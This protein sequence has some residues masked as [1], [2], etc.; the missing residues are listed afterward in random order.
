MTCSN[1]CAMRWISCANWVRPTTA[2]TAPIGICPPSARTGRTGDSAIGCR[3]IELLRDAWLAVREIDRARAARIAQAWFDLPYPTFKRLALFAAS[4]DGCIAPEQ[5]VDWLAGRDAWWLWSVDTRREM[6]RLLVLQG[7]ASDTGARRTTG[8]GHPGWPAARDVPRRHR[9]GSLARLGGSLGLAASGQAECI[10]RGALGQLGEARLAELS[11]C[12][13][14]WQLAA[15]ERDEFSHWMSGTGDPDYEESRDVD[16]APRKRRELVQWLKQPPAS[17]GARSTRTLGA[18]SAARGSFT[19]CTR[20]VIWHGRAMAGRALAR[21]AAG[22]ERRRAWCCGPG[23]SPRR[24]CRPCRT[25]CLQEIAHGVTWWLEAVSKSI[26]RHEDILLHMCRRVLALP[27]Q[28]GRW[29]RGDRAARHRGHQSPHR[30]RHAG[31]AQSVV[32]ARAQ[33]Q[34][35]ASGGHWSPLFTQLCDVRVERFRHGRVLLASRLIAFFRVD[36]PWTEQYLL[37]LFDWTIDPVEAKAAWEGFLWSPRLY[38][39]LLIA[40]KPQFLDTAPPLRRVG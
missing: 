33:R 16:I 24:W 4:Q 23:D 15:N 40:F 38:R 13:P 21:G 9:A 19:A 34:R 18:T 1:C 28:D 39:P 2:A 36:R 30:P 32:Q 8:V 26:D 3:L 17:N 14:Q 22:L 7:A 5:W 29:I 31:P 20:C 10:R 27:H 6:L 25:Q 11:A 12:H 35:R 37:P